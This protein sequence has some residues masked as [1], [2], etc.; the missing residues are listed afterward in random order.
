MALFARDIV[1]YIDP[2][3]VPDGVRD[4]TAG[5]YAAA[6]VAAALIYDSGEFLP[7]GSFPNSDRNR[8]VCTFDKEVSKIT[9]GCYAMIRIDSLP[10]QLLLGKLVAP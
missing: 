7:E 3:A 2:S 9:S 5:G 10:G 8:S 1:G 4:N 6:V